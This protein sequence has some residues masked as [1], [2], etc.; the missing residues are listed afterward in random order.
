MPNGRKSEAQREAAALL[1]ARGL[2]VKTV[3]AKT[4]IGERTLR[5]W[6]QDGAFI[7][8]IRQLQG[9]M[10]DHTIA[11]LASAGPKFVKALVD[12]IEDPVEKGSVKVSAANAGL[13]HMFR[14]RKLGHVAQHV[15][16][17][18]RLLLVDEGEH[19][20][21]RRR[22]YAQAVAQVDMPTALAILQDLASLQGV[23][24]SAGGPVVVLN[25][26]ER[27]VDNQGQPLEN[28][29]R[30]VLPERLGGADYAGTG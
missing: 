10:V 23:G 22:L 6:Q 15:E 12:R 7:D 5:G 9:Q 27:A 13:A 21:E 25:V 19:Q 18:E 17:L 11:K 2:S 14:G 16:E 28:P 4:G 26:I 20:A 8:R 1:L 3:A 24:Q 30:V 29:P